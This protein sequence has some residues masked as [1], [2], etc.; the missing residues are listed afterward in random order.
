MRFESR[1][2]GEL[3]RDV[4]A[5]QVER[6]VGFRKAHPYK[7]T[8]IGDVE[9]EYIAAGRGEAAILLLPG[10]LGTGESLFLSL[11]HYVGNYRVLAP[12]YAP[13]AT[14]AELADGVAA[15]MAKEAIDK[16]HVLGGSYGGFVAQVFARRHP[17]R[18]DRLVL[19]HCAPPDARRGRRIGWALRGLELLPMSLL[20]GLFRR[21]VAGLL[22]QRHP[23]ADLF[24][25]YLEEALSH[26][27]TRESLLCIYRRLVDFDTHYTFT[28]QDLIEWAGAVLL[29]MADDDPSTPEP[30][31]KRCGPSIRRRR[32]ICS[33]ARGT[34]PRSS[35]RR[36]TS[37]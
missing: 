27:L 12:S 22:P 20:R 11:P 23:E 9:W 10:A 18:T 33:L 29:I 30:C 7:R 15:V 34:P 3:Y 36:S 4:S 2:I 24:R 1:R 25:A 35:N 5:E 32:P 14:M 26:H 16:A 37:R 31:A 17:E 13:V 28:P 8:T 21:A 6:L 19:S